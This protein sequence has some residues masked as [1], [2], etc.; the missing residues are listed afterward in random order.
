MQRHQEVTFLSD[1]GETVRDLQRYLN[2]QAEH[3]LD[4]FH[5]GM[6]SRMLLQAA[7]WLPRVINTEDGEEPSTLYNPVLK[8]LE[9]TK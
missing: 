7:K 1:E 4:W 9:R 2:L 8:T 5:P 3:P 6:R